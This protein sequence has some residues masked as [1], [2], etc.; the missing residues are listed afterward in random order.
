[1]MHTIDDEVKAVDWIN[2]HAAEIK[3]AVD[4]DNSKAK[5]IISAYRFYHSF[6]GPAE[7]GMLIA[8]IEEFRREVK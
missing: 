8:A 5:A 4:K 1:M 6:P 2:E 3:A 7:A